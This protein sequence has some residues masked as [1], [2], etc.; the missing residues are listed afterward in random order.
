ME[1]P[2]YSILIW[3]I[4]SCCSLP[5]GNK[6]LFVNHPKVPSSSF[7]FFKCPQ[8]F[9]IS[10][11]GRDNLYKLIQP[12]NSIV[13]VC[14]AP[15]LFKPLHHCMAR[16]SPLLEH[17]SKSLPMKALA[18]EL[19]SCTRDYC[20]SHTP[21][22]GS[23]LSSKGSSKLIHLTS[24]PVLVL[25]QTHTVMQQGVRILTGRQCL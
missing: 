25:Q 23:I 4:N 19:P 18:T 7:S 15:V 14:I 2:Y 17:S 9:M 11:K 6:G 13:F 3:I 1:A 5:V 10:L 12:I 20:A 22:R 8:L 24:E 16:L 21:G